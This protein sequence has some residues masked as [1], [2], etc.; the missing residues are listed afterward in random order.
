[1][2]RKPIKIFQTGNKNGGA[3]V[4]AWNVENQIMLARSNKIWKVNNT[5]ALERVLEQQNHYWGRGR[6]RER[7]SKIITATSKHK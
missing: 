2:N 7:E 4:W 6:G 3:A 5:S 1:M